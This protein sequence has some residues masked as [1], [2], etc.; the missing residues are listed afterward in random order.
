MV[1]MTPIVAAWIDA[2]ELLSC[3]QWPKVTLQGKNLKVQFP[4]WKPGNVKKHERGIIRGFSSKSRLRLLK[5]MATVD[6][7][8][9][10]NSL[11][12]TLTYP[13]H[14]IH[15]DAW[16]RNRERYLL[17]RYVE[18]YAGKHVSGVW[19][20]EWKPRLTGMFVGRL[21]PHV[22]LLLF[23][24]PE[25]GKE[26]IRS[27]WK[28]IIKYEEFVSVDAQAI[29]IGEAAA[30]YVSKYCGKVEHPQYL[31]NV[32]YLNR[33]GRHYGYTR[34]KE[35][36]VCKKIQFPVLDPDLIEYLRTKAS[37]K[38]PY[39]SLKYPD[40]FTL[41]GEF[42]KQIGDEVLKIALDRQAAS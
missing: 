6:W 19:R 42:A 23:N 36:P 35:I 25:I 28:T 32:P 4:P 22:H 24:C 20:V 37:A 13:D 34:S 40:S 39:L 15:V 27:W 9:V 10:G 2:L 5:R 33:T 21:L 29:P 26:T 31:D 11:F 7:R 17:H 41:L 1:P 8:S 18:K 38:L 16:K 14:V 12:I 30:C 3:G